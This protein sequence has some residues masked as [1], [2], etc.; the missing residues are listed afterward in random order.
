MWGLALGRVQV[1]GRA[2][3]SGRARALVRAQE[4]APVP[5]LAQDLVQVQVRDWVSALASGSVG[6]QVPARARRR[7]NR[8]RLRPV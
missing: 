2:Q 8:L 7:A 6:V 3:V 5:A 1:Q 4:L